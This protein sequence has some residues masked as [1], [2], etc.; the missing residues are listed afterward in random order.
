M[1]TAIA[2]R[3]IAEKPWTF[4]LGVGIVRNANL[5]RMQ[6]NKLINTPTYAYDTPLNINTGGI[7][8]E[9]LSHWQQKGRWIVG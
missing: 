1:N 3:K 2:P 6:R 4:A 9:R 5:I 8:M 7:I